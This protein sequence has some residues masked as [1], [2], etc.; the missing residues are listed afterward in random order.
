MMSGPQNHNPLK[1]RLIYAYSMSKIHFACLG[2]PF[3]HKSQE[4]V[5]FY[6]EQACKNK[7]TE[8]NREVPANAW[9]PLCT[10]QCRISN[11]EAM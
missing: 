8:K 1:S 5:L 10:V 9:F 4:L 11:Y 7:V 6:C 2:I 3:L